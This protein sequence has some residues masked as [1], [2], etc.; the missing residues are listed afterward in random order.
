MAENVLSMENITKVYGNGFVANKNVNLTVY[1]GEIHAICGENGAGKTTLMKI[2][3]GIEKSDNGKILLRG[4]Q[5]EIDKP[6]M[7]IKHGIGMVHQHFML[8]PSFTVAEN[9]V[10]GMEPRKLGL[11][12][13]ESAIKITKEASEKYN[14]IVDPLAKI[15][16]L[17]V[18]LKQKVEI[19]KVLIRGAKILIFD[20]P[21]A[22]LP[23]KKQRNCL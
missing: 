10:I 11:F 4:E 22:V 18:G 3:F 16:D 9:M 1:Q 15:E 19:L 21:T 7:A 5:I 20:E 2:L 13:M 8:V 6:S 14:L 17:P 23:P 12:D